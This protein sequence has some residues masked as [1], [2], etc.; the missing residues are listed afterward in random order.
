MRFLTLICLF[1]LGCRAK[2]VI[3]QNSVD[4]SPIESDDTDTGEVVDPPEDPPE[5]PP[6]EYPG[7]I[8]A[9]SSCDGTITLTAEGFTWQNL[10]G[11]C[12]IAGP[13]T[14]SEG[15]LTWPEIDTTRCDDQ[16]WWIGIFTDGAPTFNPAVSA[17]RL[18]LVPVGPYAS[19]TVAQFEQM[20]DA[21]QWEL[22]TPEGYINQVRLCFADGSFFGGRYANL[23][24]SCEFLSCA[25]NIE[26]QILGDGTEQW[27]T[28]CG[29]GCP[30]GGI[31]TVDSRTDD[32]MSG[33]YFGH[34][35]ARTLE[36]TFTGTRL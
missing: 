7:P 12:T 19:G 27:I 36:G 28:E 10:S 18:S 35:C 33:V 11:S 13:S 25:G 16:P 17:T 2:A 23:D 8:G 20:L 31:I 32:S 24:G 6:D 30:C 26:N 9:W 29:G 3:E 15:T 1:S 4:T 22:E 5:D 34:N 14:Y 21:E